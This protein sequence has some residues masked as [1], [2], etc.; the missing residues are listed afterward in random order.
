MLL[1]LHLHYKIK[2]FKPD[3]IRLGTLPHLHGSSLG[4]G[5][6]EVLPLPVLI[7]HMGKNDM[8]IAA[9]P[10]QLCAICRPGEVKDTECVGLFHGV[11]PLGD[12]DKVGKRNNS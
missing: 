11:G 3:Q 8:A 6:L 1:T 4:E 12:R 10:S 5:D 9:G 2:H 7:H